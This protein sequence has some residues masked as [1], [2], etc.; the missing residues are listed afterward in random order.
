MT[1]EWAVVTG[2][3]AGLGIAFAEH[4][5]KQGSDIILAAR[6]QDKLEEVADKLAHRH[7]IRTEVRAVDLASETGRADFVEE[8][9]A[10]PVHT[11]VNNAGFG[12]VGKFAELAP[13]RLAQE[14][15]LDVGALTE[16]SRAVVEGMIGRRR[17]AIIN[18]A[19]TAAFQPIPDM[20]VYAAAKSYVL[21]FTIALWH[22]LYATGVRA[23][24]I[25]PGPTDTEFFANAGDDGVLTQRRR[26]DQVVET[27]FKALE[28]HRPF[29]IDG[30]R[31][32]VLALA[33]RFA[34]RSVQARV[35]KM[36]IHNT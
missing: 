36:V 24:A 15:S 20:A 35:A 12:S 3:S 28:E 5:A 16:L 30:A 9:H 19:S 27:A 13:A 25:C 10:T 7:G 4:L 23:V 1:K 21:Q 14:T 2:A 34:P 32:R 11:L 8:I 29:A 6:R 17:G 22:E 26:P 33:N 18:V 31:N